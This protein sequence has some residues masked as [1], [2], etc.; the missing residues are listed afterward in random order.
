MIRLDF[1]R[2]GRGG[3][4]MGKARFIEREIAEASQQ[5]VLDVL[6]SLI[7]AASE[8]CASRSALSGLDYLDGL[9]T[10]A[11]ALNQALD[12]IARRAEP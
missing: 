4:S 3:V 12:V 6:T 11:K 8:H 7:E 9:L 5:H 2:K 10:D 1:H